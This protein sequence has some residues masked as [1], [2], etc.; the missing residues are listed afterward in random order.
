[1]KAI[2]ENGQLQLLKKDF[3]YT[4]YEYNFT[5]S[6]E[7]NQV[8]EDYAKRKFFAALLRKQAIINY[9]NQNTL[10]FQEGAI[11]E[12]DDYDAE[13]DIEFLKSLDVANTVKNNEPMI[14]L[15]PKVDIIK[16]VMQRYKALFHIDMNRSLK[17]EF[18]VPQQFIKTKPAQAGFY[19]AHLAVTQ[20]IR[21]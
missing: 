10:S 12:I 2:F 3:S 4:K 18:E 17:V 13:K 14:G 15:M 20:K 19:W 5:I 9:N 6:P 11:Y 7:N 21:G 16:Q 8:R 1:M